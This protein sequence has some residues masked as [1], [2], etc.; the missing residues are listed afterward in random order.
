MPIPPAPTNLQASG[1]FRNIIVTWD[2]QIYTGHSFVQV[3]RHTSDV[4]ASATMVAQVSGFTGVYSD[5]VGPGSTFYYWVRAI[6]QNGVPGPFNSSTGTQG[7]TSPDVTFLLNALTNAITSSQL[8]TALA[9]EISDAT[10]NITSLQNT[11]GSTAAAAA[12]A[13]AAAASQA[14]ALLN[15]QGAETAEDAA[16]IAKTAAETA[17][18]AA[19]V[20]A[21]NSANSATGAAGSASTAATHASTAATAATN[22]SNSASAASTQASNAAARR[23]CRQERV[24]QSSAMSTARLPSPSNPARH[25]AWMHACISPSSCPRRTPCP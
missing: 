1:A 7:A 8:A 25:P 10:T 24:A 16:V 4:I 23:P 3:W 19:G 20:S 11:Y 15:Q 14:A 21:T 5:A 17:Q 18:A 9:T 6:N 22:A 2:L 13:A 12:S